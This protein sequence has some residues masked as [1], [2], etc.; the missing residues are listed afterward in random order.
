[1]KKAQVVTRI[2]R[3]VAAVKVH[4]WLDEWDKVSYNRKERRRHPEPHFY[5]FTLPA[6][7]LKAL[8]GI[9]RRTT[10]GRQAGADD[11]G[12]QRRYE[13]DRAQEINRFIRYG[14]P[15]SVMGQRDSP[16]YQ[17]LRKPGWLPTAIVVNILGAEDE[18]G[19]ERV[20]T[21]DL[22]SVESSNGVTSRILLPR[23]FTGHGWK[24]QTLYP[25][26]VIDGQ[27]RLWAFEDRP[28]EEEFDLPVV[29]FH[30]LDISWQAYLFWTI[31]IKPIRINAS[32]AFDLYPLLRTE[33]WL[34]T[35][36]RAIVYRETRAQELVES[37]WAHPKSPWHH[38]INMLGEP[39]L[40][41]QMVSQAAWI[42]SLIATYVKAWE[43]RR[44]RIGGLFGAR[45]G[46]NEEV[47]PWSR[48]QQAAFLIFA[49][50]TLREAVKSCDEPWARALRSSKER[51][52]SVPGDVAFYG[53]QTLL[54]TDQGI[55][56]F[57]HVTND[58][59][60]VQAHEL[61][62]T[63]WRAT[64]EQTAPDEE[65]VSKALTSLRQEP[66]ANFLTNVAKGLAEYDWRTSSA[67]GL[68]DNLRLVKAAFRGSGGYRELRH[69][70]LRHLAASTKV[71]RPAQQVLT[72]LGYN[73]K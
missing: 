14:F 26:E 70:L 50:E 33:D 46:A 25:I 20:A 64:P 72:L 29:A 60:Y 21:N 19:G 43:G 67:P 35:A 9:Q 65:G 68:S 41:Q 48:A 58:L 51:N 71:G 47:L 49:G 57:L 37:L 30:S 10:V 54:S 7:A 28:P 4:Q 55:R 45:M 53:S 23:N 34:E 40:K 8:S 1:M 31:N 66:V 13:P 16:E 2:G 3:E 15:L 42:R 61:R 12:I 11:L 18:R 17:N 62:L 22:M 38:R 52:R 73:K 59:C 32:L 36:D 63:K 44:V 39:G 5:L 56:G 69:Q 24:P 27:H 6:A